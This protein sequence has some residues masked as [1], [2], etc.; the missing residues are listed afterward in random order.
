M[1]IDTLIN[2]STSI[3]T[4]LA[5][6]VALGVSVVPAML[7]KRK[8]RISAEKRV[9]FSLR[10]LRQAIKDYRHFNPTKYVIDDGIVHYA[11]EPKA[12]KLQVNLN[13]EKEI[14]AI[15]LLLEH[16]RQKHQHPVWTTV[17][18]LRK[19]STGY[20]CEE[21]EWNSLDKIIESSI[22]SL[23]ER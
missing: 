1:S 13:L 14:D 15:L 19:I 6:I 21:T 4:F 9:V 17:E 20:P 12:L 5:V 2:L 10:L 18:T 16:L 22:E 7:N 3:A 23:S 11:Y 8:Q